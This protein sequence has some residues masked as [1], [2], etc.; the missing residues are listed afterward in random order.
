MVGLLNSFDNPHVGRHLTVDA[1]KRTHD[2]LE[3]AE[4]MA[5]PNLPIRETLDWSRLPLLVSNNHEV[6]MV[7]ITR[8]SG[9][10][11][12]GSKNAHNT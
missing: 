3:M 10:T 9:H 4:N 8:R 5:P 2:R 12:S 11:R 7:G 6:R 1:W